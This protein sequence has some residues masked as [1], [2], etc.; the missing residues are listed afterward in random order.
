MHF[1]FALELSDIDLWNID[2]LDTHL[3][4]LDTNIPSKHFVCLQDVLKTSSRYVFK[5]S[6]RHVFKTCSRCLLKA[7]WRRPKRNNFS[8][9]K[10]SLRRLKDV[11]EDVKLLCWRR[12]QDVLKT[13]KCLL[14]YRAFKNRILALRKPSI[15]WMKIYYKMK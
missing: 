15:L 12:L 8:S 1:G 14:G 9:S 5:T 4:F 3:D 11:L 6:P 13:N 2:L 10:T 7:S